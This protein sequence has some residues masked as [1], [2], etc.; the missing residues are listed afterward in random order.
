MQVTATQIAYRAL[1]DIGCLRPGQSTSS[2]V[3]NDMLSA[4][5]EMIDQWLLDQLMVFSVRADIYNLVA[6]QQVYTIGPVGANFIA[7]RPTEVQDA[8]ILL[9]NVSPVVRLAMEIINVDTWAAIRVRVIPSAI[10]LMLYYDKNF[11]PV[12]GFA[13]LNMWPGPLLNYQLE[14]FSWQQ[15]QS[16]A[17]L[18]TSY[19][20]PPG[21]A[22][23]LRKNL[24]VEIVPM[25]EIYS[26][27]S[28][29]EAPR[30]DMVDRVTEQARHA[31][32]EIQ[33]YNA[34]TPRLTIDEAYR[35]GRGAAWNY[36]I[37]EAVTRG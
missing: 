16:F 3:L 8:N 30:P 1:R 2:D 20:I 11:D 15:L 22:T 31:K 21:Y 35:A 14:L 24:S 26:K 13:T 4:L 36:A 37:G 19:N 25:M 17:D 29:T 6:S 5:N 7:P 27:L 33:S 9:T 18:V 10:P 12:N 28:R 32:E 23:A 34:P